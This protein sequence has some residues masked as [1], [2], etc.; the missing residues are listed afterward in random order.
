MLAALLRMAVRL[1][2]KFSN[3]EREVL[4]DLAIDFGEKTFWQ[5][6]DEAAR[7]M[8]DDGAIRDAALAID[9]QAARE[10]I[11]QLVWTV[12]SSD[13]VQQ[14]EQAMLDWL[15]ESWQLAPDAGAYR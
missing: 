11:F 1:D 9:N 13:S 5:L 4:E 8:G 6:M 14:R 3:A 7:T 10:L 2:G 12:A 15:R